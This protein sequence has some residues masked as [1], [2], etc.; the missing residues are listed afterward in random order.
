MI[1]GERYVNAFK[2]AV[3]LLK[4]VDPKMTFA[5]LF[6]DM[7]E[8]G[9]TNAEVKRAMLELGISITSVD[10]KFPD[11]LPILSKIREMEKRI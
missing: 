5:S 10:S 7:H 4:S 3:K 1:D 11:I 6:K 9:K 2:L 8:R